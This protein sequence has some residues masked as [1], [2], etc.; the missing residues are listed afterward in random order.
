VYLHAKEAGPEKA[1]SNPQLRGAFWTEIEG[2]VVDPGEAHR[3]H[4]RTL[5]LRDAVSHCCEVL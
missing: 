3:H 1:T 5:R 4:R 2:R